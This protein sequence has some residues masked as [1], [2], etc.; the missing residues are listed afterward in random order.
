MSYE[1][2]IH[3]I[4]V[5]LSFYFLTIL[6]FLIPQSDYSGSEPNAN[7]TSLFFI[8]AELIL[9]QHRKIGDH[10]VHNEV[11]PQLIDTMFAPIQMTEQIK[12]KLLYST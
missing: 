12:C 4:T 9:E 11:A 3:I 6:P 8:N 1:F 5:L 10:I 2:R 7:Y